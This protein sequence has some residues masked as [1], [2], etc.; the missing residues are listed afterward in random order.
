M[1]CAASGEEDLDG[2]FGLDGAVKTDSGGADSGKKD[3]GST[4]SCVPTCS[5]DQD[6]QN[7]C[8]A[9]PNGINCC[10][11]STGI[12]YAYASQVCPAPIP[13]AGFD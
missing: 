4:T 12:C 5:T 3:G 1:G 11:T 8:P 13:D 10:D 7:S 2:G 9:V 6:C